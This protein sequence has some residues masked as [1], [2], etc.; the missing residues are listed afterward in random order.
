MISITDKTLKDLE[1]N[2]VL[3]AVAAGCTTEPGKEKALTIAP[4]KK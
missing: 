4:Y 3:D 1:F 2:T